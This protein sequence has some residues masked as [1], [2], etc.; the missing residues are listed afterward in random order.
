M[1]PKF[2]GSHKV[3]RKV[4]EMTY[5]LEL[6][7]TSKIDSVFH[8]SYLKQVLRKKVQVQTKLLELDERERIMMESQEL[9]KE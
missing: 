7:L 3:L 9:L 2:Y 5:Q 6:L 8:V 1:T 4:G